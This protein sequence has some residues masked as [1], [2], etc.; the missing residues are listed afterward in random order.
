MQEI[1]YQQTRE[2]DSLIYIDCRTKKEYQKAT[3]PGA[4]NI[5]ILN[6]EQRAKVG[7]I[8][9]HQT[10]AK[11]KMLAVKL[12]APKIPKL[13]EKVQSA[14]ENYKNILFF[15]SRGGLRSES[16]A[17]FAQLAGLKKIYKLSGGYKSYR[18]FILNQL[19]DYQLE[20]KLVVLHG[21]TGVGKTELLYKLSNKGFNIID[22]EKLANHRGSAF[23]GIGLGRPRNA[24]AFDSLLWEKLE[25]IDNNNLIIIEAESKRIGQSVLPDFLIEKMSNGIQILIKSSL[26]KRAQRIVSEYA[27]SYQNNPDSF[28]N[29]AI[30]SL[31]SIKKHLI[32]NLGKQGY[33]KLIKNCQQGQLEKVIITLFK[34]YYDP[35]YK[36]S[37][38]KHEFDLIIENNQIKEISSKIYDYLTTLK[39]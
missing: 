6:D 30:E 2:I 20:N 5:P 10:P 15:C 14:S 32:N 29:R 25:S 22:L 21:Y 38:D 26:N 39:A 36:H 13:L 17:R 7:T 1:N 31:N 19:E 4:I 11:A 37:L 3:I 35:L 34:N 8:Y 27:A 24:K 12:V 18:R 33:Q 23:G 28:I 9:T 16:L